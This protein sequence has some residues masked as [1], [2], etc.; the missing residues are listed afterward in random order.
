MGL[1]YMLE[2]DVNPITGRG[3]G[4]PKMKISTKHRRTRLLLKKRSNRK[5]SCDTKDWI[6]G[7][8]AYFMSAFTL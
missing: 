4:S 8:E 3:S 5:I 1:E 6:K 2:V 7:Q